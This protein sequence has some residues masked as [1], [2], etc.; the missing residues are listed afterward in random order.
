MTNAMF[1]GFVK[2]TVLFLFFGAIVWIIKK[3]LK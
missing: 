1:R 3:I 2:A